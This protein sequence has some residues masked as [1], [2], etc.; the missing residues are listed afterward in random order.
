MRIGRFAAGAMALASAAI[1]ATSGIAA[2][3]GTSGIGSDHVYSGRQDTPSV[4]LHKGIGVAEYQYRISV[5]TGDRSGAGTDAN[6]YIT[7][8]GARGVAGPIKLDNSE[9]NFERG[10]TDRFTL[11]LPDVGR[12]QRINIRHD[13]SGEKPG[14]YLNKVTIDVNGDH[15]K[16]P[17]NRWL[18][19]D[20]D[21]KKTEVNLSRA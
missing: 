17:C 1:M 4:L 13:N 11:G 15:P 14:W 16:F 18:A 5:Y 19:T 3:G 12:V 8:Y 7:I 6:V 10:K 2:A 9:N 20:E 21:D